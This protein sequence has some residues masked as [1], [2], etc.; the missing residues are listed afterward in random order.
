VYRLHPA[1][2]SY[3]DKYARANVAILEGAREEAADGRERR[4]AARG[5][6][7]ARAVLHLT[8]AYEAAADGDTSRARR[9]AWHALRGEGKVR[10]RAGFMLIAPRLGARIHVRRRDDVAGWIDT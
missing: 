8:E 4:A 7:H 6:R 5:V 2:S 9:A 10:T 3:G 1:S